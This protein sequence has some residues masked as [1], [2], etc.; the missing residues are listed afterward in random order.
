MGWCGEHDFGSILRERCGFVGIIQRMRMT[1]H[2]YGY[3]KYLTSMC[4]PVAAFPSGNGTNWSTSW[5]IEHDKLLTS[6]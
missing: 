5:Y 6:F 3:G 4:V 1:P 2:P